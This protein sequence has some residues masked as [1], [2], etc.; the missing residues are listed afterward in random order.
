MRSFNQ[1]LSYLAIQPRQGDIQTSSETMNPMRCAEVNFGV[2]RYF[3]RQS[4]PLFGS[5]DL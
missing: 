2:D 4:D 5:H 3:R 1:R